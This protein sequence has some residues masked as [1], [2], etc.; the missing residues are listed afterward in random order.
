MFLVN[1]HEALGLKPDEVLDMSLTL[2]H[3]MLAEY[4]YMWRERNKED[5]EDE[6]GEFEW[7]E[8]PDWNDPSKTVRMKKYSDVG[9]F[10]K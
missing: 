8:M 6:N 9:S 7:I 4:S 3:S 1:V 10:V 5:A 2:I